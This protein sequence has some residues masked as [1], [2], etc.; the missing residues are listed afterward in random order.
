MEAI[1]E[2]L[3]SLQLNMLQVMSAGMFIFLIGYLIGS[4]KV[5]KLTHEVYSLQKDV[6]DLNEEL[7][8][9][10]QVSDTPVIGLKTDMKQAKLAK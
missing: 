6:L 9:G 4:K 8:Y 1:L 3:R 10:N 7:L 2:L 5:R